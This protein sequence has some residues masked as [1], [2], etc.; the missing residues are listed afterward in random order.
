MIKILKKTR[1]K[2]TFK[3][4]T[5]TRDEVDQGLLSRPSKKIVFH[6]TKKQ[7]LVQVGGPCCYKLRFFDAIKEETKLLVTCSKPPFH[8]HFSR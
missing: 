2:H 6:F 4:D 7:I 5:K 8:R 3:Q 1:E